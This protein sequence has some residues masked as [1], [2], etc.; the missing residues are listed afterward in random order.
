MLTQGTLVDEAL[1]GTPQVEAQG[2][3]GGGD[4]GRYSAL[5]LKRWAGCEQGLRARRAPAVR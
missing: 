5:E 4:I 3:R 2:G 1:L